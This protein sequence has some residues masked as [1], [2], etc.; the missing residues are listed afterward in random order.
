MS[1]LIGALLACA[2]TWLFRQLN[3]LTLPGSIAAF[4]IGWIVYGLGELTFSIPLIAFFVSSSLLSRLANKSKTDNPKA[5]KSGPRD[6][7]QVLVNGLVP[8]SALLFWSSTQNELFAILFVL[9]IAASAADTWATEIGTM[10]S[11]SPVDILSF[12]K[13]EPGTSGGTTWLGSVGAIAGAF[14]IALIAF[15]VFENG[16]FS[17]I[18]NIIFITSAAFI[19]QII[20]SILGSALQARF[21][22]ECGAETEVPNHCDGKFTHQIKGLHFINNDAVNLL[23]VAFSVAAAGLFYEAYV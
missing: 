16:M 9:A 17:N 20:D 15:L 2:V 14:F 4:A 23:S 22:C 21:K 10:L 5:V 7:W 13:V 3:L 1:W 8:L 6:Q 19:S 18:T 11:R 12:R